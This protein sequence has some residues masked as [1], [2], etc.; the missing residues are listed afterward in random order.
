M[1]NT[2][3]QFCAN[4]YHC[5]NIVYNIA[6]L[7]TTLQYCSQHCDIV[8]N[9]AVLLDT[10]VTLVAISF[11][12][13]VR[14]ISSASHYYLRHLNSF[15]SSLVTLPRSTAMQCGGSCVIC[16]VTTTAFS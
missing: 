15:A 2:I 6:I 16:H 13:C 5:C 11:D 3:T 12:Y 10:I 9:I 4:C 8:Y 7:F 14:L 1:L